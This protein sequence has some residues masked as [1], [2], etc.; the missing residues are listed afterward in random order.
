MVERLNTR[1]SQKKL[2]IELDRCDPYSSEIADEVSSELTVNQDSPIET[3]D[4]STLNRI[5]HKT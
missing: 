4:S 2:K 5:G 1:Y 3:S